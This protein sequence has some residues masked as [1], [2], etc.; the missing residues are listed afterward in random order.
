MQRRSVL[1]DVEATQVALRM[2]RESVARR[3]G[4]GIFDHLEIAIRQSLKG[5]TFYLFPVAIKHK[6]NIWEKGSIQLINIKMEFI[7]DGDKAEKRVLMP[8]DRITIVKGNDSSDA[9]IF[10]QV[11]S[12]LS[13]SKEEVILIK[14]DD[15]GSY[16]EFLKTMSQE[17]T[18]HNTFGYMCSNNLERLLQ[19]DSKALDM[20]KI[21]TPLTPNDS[22]SDLEA[23]V[24]KVAAVGNVLAPDIIEREI[25]GL[26]W[27]KTRSIMFSQRIG[28]LA[29]VQKLAEILAHD[30]SFTSLDLSRNSID[31]TGSTMIENM[32]HHN[33]TLTELNLNRC[34]LG[35]EGVRRIA[36]ALLVNTTIKKLYLDENGIQFYGC[37]A[38][39]SSLVA[40]NDL[41]VLTLAKNG[42]GHKGANCF[43]EVLGAN[44]SLGTCNYSLTHLDLNHQVKGCKIGEWGATALGHAL[45]NPSCELKVLKMAR[46]NIGFEGIRHVSAAL[47]QNNTI[48]E[49]DVGGINYFTIAGAMQ[50][51]HAVTFNQSL[52]ILNVG[53]F[54]LPVY[55]VKGNHYIEI[56]ENG[57]RTQ[58]DAPEVV[59]LSDG[60][61][62]K[63]NHPNPS[64]DIKRLNKAMQDEMAIVV[65]HLLVD[66]KRM[67]TLRLIDPNPDSPEFEL[68]ELPVQKLI[69]NNLTGQDVVD[70]L[71]LSNK[72]LKSIHMII[73]GFLVAYNEKLVELAVHGNDFADTEGENYLCFGLRKNPN[74][75]IKKSCWP[76]SRRYAQSYKALASLD[77]AC[78]SGVIL[79]PQR[80]EGL[81][82]RSLTA[83]SAILFY[84]GLYADINA[85]YIMA[86]ERI[87][88]R[89]YWVI[90]TVFLLLPTVLV[91]FNSIRNL[92][93]EDLHKL[94][95]E[96]AIT[97][98][99]MSMLVHATYSV[100]Y[101]VETSEMLDYKFVMGIYRQLPSIAFQM[102][103]LF[104][105]CHTQGVFSYSICFAIFTSIIGTIVIFIML[106]DRIQSRRMAMLPLDKQPY[107]A[108][109]IASAYACCGCGNDD[110]NVENMINWNA[111]YTSHY[112][113]AYVHQLLSLIPRIIAFSWLLAT[114]NTNECLSIFAY[115]ICR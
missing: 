64:E 109:V 77:G 24:A 5:T 105:M 65:A 76:V 53:D 95:K 101:S 81:F 35:D 10:L 71:D 85:I 31:V 89:T 37:E 110:E 3:I 92:I 4:E 50:L 108:V 46:N 18:V 87:Y 19:Y 27:N 42:V 84:I 82:Y 74:I 79:E 28:D 30:D 98:F 90:S 51:A 7:P 36:D 83:C 11:I 13:D 39:A 68:I 112:T 12:Y 38:L 32:M 96:V 45:R 70:R 61:Y 16:E 63:K 102:Y 25:K 57:R 69:G 34:N 54:E 104:Y 20:K 55:Q 67:Q 75:Q 9:S 66:N 88:P 99:Q 59:D 40:N 100:L 41:Q 33:I 72:G 113:W 78:A 94:C 23:S 22:A 115:L 114:L 107:C 52:Q 86:T 60:G 62:F 80:L 111:F 43:A 97:T 56:S 73:V 49:L 17:A 48:E 1:K 14:F 58:K 2:K 91:M 8:L 44:T 26:K 29:T 93:F 21:E 106:F 15:Q 6:T 47:F 103:I